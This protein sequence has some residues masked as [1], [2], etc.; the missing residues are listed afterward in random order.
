MKDGG[1]ALGNF[2]ATS[3]GHI[4]DFYEIEKHKL[5]EGGSGAVR[6]GRDKH[7]G[8]F[9]AIKTIRKKGVQEPEKLK[10]EIDIMRLLERSRGSSQHCALPREL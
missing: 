6:K 3:T 5:G 4:E 10:E 1:F 7:T 8:R 2:A 9:Y